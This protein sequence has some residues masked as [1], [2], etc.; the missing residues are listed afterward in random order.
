VLV[1]CDVFTQSV[2]VLRL[3][4]QRLNWN[5]ATGT[6]QYPYTRCTSSCTKYGSRSTASA[7]SLDI[8]P[9]E[10][11][12]NC[13]THKIKNETANAVVQQHIRKLLTMGIL[14]PETC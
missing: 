4:L 2:N 12:P 9:D 10:P 11:H 5:E 1:V 6:G 3:I 13:S 14:M 7:G 8:T